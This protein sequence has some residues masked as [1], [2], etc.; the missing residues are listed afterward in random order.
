MAQHA[1]QTD[2][3]DDTLRRLAHRRVGVRAVK[4]TRA[5][6]TI[7]ACA[8]LS[9]VPEPT[10]PDPDAEPPVS[11]RQWEAS[12]MRWRRL[13]TVF[14]LLQPEESL[15]RQGKDQVREHLFSTSTKQDYTLE[16]EKGFWSSNFVQEYG[17]G[18]LIQEGGFALP[19]V[20]RPKKGREGLR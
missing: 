12:M 18:M 9:A 4:A 11:K 14:L 7:R 10:V 3:A 1:T 20:C 16:E 8:W 13:M 5:Y 15:Q 2:R 17:L 19:L 6:R